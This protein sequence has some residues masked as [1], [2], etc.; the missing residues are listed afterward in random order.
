[1]PSAGPVRAF[2]SY[3]H[4]DHAWRDAVL[5]HLGWLRH[6]G[7]LDLFDDRQIEPGTQWDPRIK[8][9]LEAADIVVLLLSPYFLNSRYCLV[10]EL[11][12]AL[13]RQREGSAELFP[14]VCDHV[15]LHGS[16]ITKHQ[17][18]PQGADSDLKP[19]TG[20]D[21]FN[22]PLAAIAERISAVVDRIERDPA[23]AAAA[24]V[25]APWLPTEPSGRTWRLPVPPPRCFG[26]AEDTRRLIAALLAERPA[27]IVVLGGAGIGKSTLVREVASH[28]DVVGRYGERRAWVAL[29]KVSG[30]DALVGAVHDAL[31]LPAEP[32]PWA[33]IEA[34]LGAG[35]ALLV[36]D[37]LETPWE[38]RESAAEAVLERLAAIPGLLLL[39]TI[40]SGDA[41]LRP[42]WGTSLEVLRLTS[43]HDRDLLLDIA[44]DI[45]PDDP[46]LPDALVALD[47]W[48]LAIELFAAQAAGLGNLEPA[49]RRWQTERGAMLDRGEAEPDRLTSLAVSL[50]FSLSSPRLRL[51]PPHRADAPIRLY[52]MLGRLPDGLAHGDAELLLPGEGNAAAMVLVRT[53]LARLEAG[54]LR[55]LAPVRE[56]AARGALAP[57][58]ALALRGHYLGLAD[59]LRRYFDGDHRGVDL[60]RLRAELINIEA[61]IGHALETTTGDEARLFRRELALLS[62]AIGE[63]RH[64]LGKLDLALAIYFR[65]VEVFLALAASA[66]DNVEP[67]FDLAIS[68]ERVADVLAMQAQIARL[69]AGGVTI[70]P[71]PTGTSRPPW[72][73]FASTSYPPG[74]PPPRLYPGSTE[75]VWVAYGD[76]HAAVTYG[77]R[78][79]TWTASRAHFLAATPS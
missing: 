38:G 14:I 69:P 8:A 41:P 70:W 37:N 33:G 36:L 40:R 39:A 71:R 72:R 27:P 78:S 45:P 7:R 68:I 79:R 25:S 42:A 75:L 9:A 23:R 13:E 59:E 46:F 32:D 53:R 20:W 34:T 52:A 3:A 28:A 56:H 26:R 65:A 58:D 43:P 21:N 31:G 51:R 2:L 48:P 55:M 18:L 1:M 73:P 19:L 6:R 29:D 54:R 74:S 67:Q 76:P 11:E 12:R 64:E 47:S 4:E 30:P 77:G 50:G 5:A 62:S 57:E 17:C 49:W 63:A 60:P 35:V 10:D 66:P 44:R 61:I 24:S 15:T 22:E 16:P